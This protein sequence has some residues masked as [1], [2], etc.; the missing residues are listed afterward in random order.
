MML[1]ELERTILNG[2]V[3][4]IKLYMDFTS[5]CLRSEAGR[6]E[7]TKLILDNGDFIIKSLM[8]LLE[9]KVQVSVNT[10]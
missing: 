4:I 3:D 8:P 9:T 1:P 6:P 2:F 7:K 10:I 5:G